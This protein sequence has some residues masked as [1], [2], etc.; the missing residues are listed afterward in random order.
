MDHRANGNN[1]MSCQCNSSS[2]KTQ[3][4]NYLKEKENFYE[5]NLATFISQYGYSVLYRY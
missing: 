3:Q 2:A 1:A 5:D 4:L